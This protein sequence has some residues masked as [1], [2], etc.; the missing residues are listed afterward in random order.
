M[1]LEKA[2]KKWDQVAQPIQVSARSRGIRHDLSHEVAGKIR[3]LAVELCNKHGLLD[4]SERLTALQQE[5]F[6]EVDRLVEQSEEDFTALSSLASDVN[7]QREKPRSPKPVASSISRT[8]MLGSSV[9]EWFRGLVELVGV[10]IGIIWYC[11]VLG[12]L[13]WMLGAFIWELYT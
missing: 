9:T 11:I 6:A 8:P 1:E 7:V 10:L 5:V 4:I 13:I 2:V 3:S 12:V